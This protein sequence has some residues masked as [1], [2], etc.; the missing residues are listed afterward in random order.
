M[1]IVSCQVEKHR[2][3]RKISQT[4]LKVGIIIGGLTLSSPHGS[5]NSFILSDG[6]ELELQLIIK[7]EN[8]ETGMKP[9]V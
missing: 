2:N 3:I 8:M 6:S 4:V 7:Q 5:P 9:G 1:G